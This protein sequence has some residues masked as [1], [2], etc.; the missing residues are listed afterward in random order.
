[1]AVNEIHQNDIGTQFRVTVYDGDTVVDISGATTKTI[2]FQKPSG[3]VVSKT[4]SFV[5]SGTD[6][7]MQYATVAG[8]L[9]EVGGWLAQA[10]LVLAD[11]TGHSDICQFEVHDNLG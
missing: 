9:D 3:T 6:G 4:A 7:V 2:K 11:W 5:T 8:D 10:Y 1:M